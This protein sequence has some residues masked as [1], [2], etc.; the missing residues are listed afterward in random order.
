MFLTTLKNKTPD[1][2]ETHHANSILV[3][4]HD[5]AESLDADCNFERKNHRSYKSSISVLPNFNLKLGLARRLK[6]TPVKNRE[7]CIKS[8]LY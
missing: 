3:E 5:L 8:F 2:I 4:K 6:Y 7:E 1:R